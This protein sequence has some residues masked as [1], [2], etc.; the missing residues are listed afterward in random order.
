VLLL[1]FAARLTPHVIVGHQDGLFRDQHAL[2]AAVGAD[3]RAHQFAQPGKHQVEHGGKGQQAHEAG[4]VVGGGMRDDFEHLVHAHQVGHERVGDAE[5]DQPE[6]QVLAPFLSDFPGRPGGFVQGFLP[7]GVA[8]IR[9][10]I[11]RNII[12]M[13]IVCG[14]AQPHHTRPNTTVNRMMNTKKVIIASPNR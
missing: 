7:V 5:G 9:Y 1:A 2:Q 11:L 3:H 14:Q 13:K 8:S 6:Q 10:S 4:P 12:S